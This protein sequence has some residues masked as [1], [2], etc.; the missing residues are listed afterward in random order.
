MSEELISSEQKILGFRIKIVRNKKWTGPHTKNCSFCLD[1]KLCNKYSIKNTS[2]D[3]P[4]RHTWS[5]TSNPNA[6][7]VTKYFC[8]EE[9]LTMWVLKHDTL[10]G[11]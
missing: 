1:F 6:Y 8:S 11:K 10:I 2:V 5:Y 3:Y 9:C 4:R 7:F